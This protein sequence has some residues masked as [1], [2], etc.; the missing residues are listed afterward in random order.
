MSRLH[1]AINRR[2]RGLTIRGGAMV[3]MCFAFPIIV[4]MTFAIV[5]YGIIWN[6]EV[7][8]NNLARECARFAAVYYSANGFVSTTSNTSSI[9]YYLEQQC[10]ATGG[11]VNYSDLPTCAGG[12]EQPCVGI[13]VNGKFEDQGSNPSHTGNIAIVTEVYN[14]PMSKKVFLLG[15]VPGLS[16]YNTTVSFSQSIM[17]E[18]Q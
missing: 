13:V 18:P 10:N 4:W 3:E 8:L 11:V 2:R 5:Q 9:Q 1:K 17:E 7:T 14:Y 15:L 12:E 16:Y 6:T